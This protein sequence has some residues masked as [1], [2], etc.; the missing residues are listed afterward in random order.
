[1]REITLDAEIRNE[2][3]RKTRRLRSEGKVPGVFYVHGEDNITFAVSERSLHQLVYTSETHVVNLKFSDGRQK[4]CI[5]R[6]IQ[7]DPVTDKPLHIDFQGLRA[8]EKVTIEIPVVVVG[9][10]PQGVRDGGV[11]QHVIHKLRISCLPKHIPDH[12]EVNAEALTI[13][14]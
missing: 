8:D 3:G 6:D 2:R 7:F 5:V 14:H 10:I 13:N 9:G 12:V 4:S 1:M 11:L